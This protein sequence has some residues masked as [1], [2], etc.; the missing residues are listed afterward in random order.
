MPIP[1][2]PNLGRIPTDHLKVSVVTKEGIA[3]L[4]KQ[5]EKMLTDKELSG[6]LRVSQS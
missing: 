6:R 1:D 3:S 5:I 2:D 4:K